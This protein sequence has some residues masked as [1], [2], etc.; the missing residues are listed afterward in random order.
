MA[1]LPE[2]SKELR[3]LNVFLTLGDQDE[4]ILQL[5]IETP[6]VAI[7]IL[8]MYKIVNQYER[9]AVLDCLSQAALATEYFTCMKEKF[10]KI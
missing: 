3:Q 10:S 8:N 7:A 2:A 1:K 4:K 5:K 9:K 6:Q